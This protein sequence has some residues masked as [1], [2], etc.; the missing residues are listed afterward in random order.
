MHRFYVSYLDLEPISHQITHVLRMNVGDQFII[1][2][3]DGIER[4]VSIQSLSPLTVSVL[5]ESQASTPSDLQLDLFVSPPKKPALH[6][7]MIAKLTEVGAHGLYFWKSQRCEFK[8][9]LKQ[10]RFTKIAQES[11]EQSGRTQLLHFSSHLFS[12]QELT[13]KL[14]SYDTVFVTTVSGGSPEGFSQRLGGGRV[15]VILG[16]EGGLTSEEV[17]QFTQLGAHQLT[18]SAPV[19]RVATAAVALSSVLLHISSTQG[20]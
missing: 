19:M 1:F 7:E 3:D 17:A 12:F 4:H 5:S 8:G 16:P 9:E 18:L 20:T 11:A 6:E 14:S 15:A 2:H 10:Q 13:E